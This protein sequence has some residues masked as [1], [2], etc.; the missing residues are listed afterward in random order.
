MA[1]QHRNP[2]SQQAD[3]NDSGTFG[4]EPSDKEGM[5]GSGGRIASGI[6]TAGGSGSNNA[7]RNP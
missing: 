5:G 3:G 2:G 1:D 7:S 6:G 4:S